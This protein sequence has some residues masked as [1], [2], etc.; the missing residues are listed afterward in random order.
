[1]AIKNL[2]NQKK[3]AELPLNVIVISIL[4]VIVLLVIIVFFTTKVGESGDTLNSLKGCDMGNTIISTSGYSQVG[5]QSIN[6]D[7]DG[8]ITSKVEC[9]NGWERV[10]MIPQTTIT[11]DDGETT[12]IDICCGQK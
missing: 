7:S 1:M 3:A 6:A 4:V 9:S 12:R 8:K 2:F 11:D 5:I 10:S